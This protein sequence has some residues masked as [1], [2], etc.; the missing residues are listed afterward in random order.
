MASL[1]PAD[2][3]DVR[4][5][6]GPDAAAAGR[7][8]VADARPAHH[9]AAGEV[10]A[11]DVLHQALQVDRRVRD[12]GLGRL[13][14]LAEVVRR[15]VRRHSYRDAGRAVD[16]KVRE[17]RR[18]NERLARCLVVVGPEVDGVRVD[19]A[20]HLRG[21]ALEPRLGVPHGGSRVVVDRAEVA[22]AV[23]QR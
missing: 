3:L 4:A 19:V 23:D 22:L 10:G 17:A 20:E 12:V 6:P 7:V 2:R 21:E 16:E 9:A 11:L 8:G 18:E 13:D 1:P 5:S 14:D 15:D